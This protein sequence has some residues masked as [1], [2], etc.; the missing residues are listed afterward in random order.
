M[1]AVSGLAVGLLQAIAVWATARQAIVWGGATAGLSAVAWLP[2]SGVIDVANQWPIF[3]LS[4]ALVVAFLQSLF[5]TR[6]LPT[7]AT[8]ATADRSR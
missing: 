5:I 1:G 7:T 8:P 3:G 2:S 4:G 6:V